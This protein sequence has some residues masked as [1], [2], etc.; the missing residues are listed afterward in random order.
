MVVSR[1]KWMVH[2][3]LKWDCASVSSSVDTEVHFRGRKLWI[4]DENLINCSDIFDNRLFQ[5]SFGLSR[6]HSRLNR[7]GIFKH[8]CL[9]SWAASCLKY[10]P[11]WSPA[12]EMLHLCT[13]IYWTQGTMSFFPPTHILMCLNLLYGSYNEYHIIIKLVTF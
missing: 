11:L 4:I 8:P 1:L 10:L 5:V 2:F 6:C 12:E 9:C 3:H 13:I 7:L